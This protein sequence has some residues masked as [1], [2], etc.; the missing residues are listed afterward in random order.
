MA[1]G[2]IARKKRKAGATDINT[3]RQERYDRKDARRK[4][5]AINKGNFKTVQ[6]TST[7][8]IPQPGTQDVTLPG[9]NISRITIK[10]K[11][12]ETADP[13]YPTRGQGGS[14]MRKAMNA[15]IERGAR[16]GTTRV[17]STYGG[18]TKPLPV[19]VGEA[20]YTSV[21][22]NPQKIPGTP[23]SERTMVMKTEK[24]VPEYNKPKRRIK[25]KETGTETV[26][27]LPKQ[28][29]NRRRKKPMRKLY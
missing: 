26:K 19:Q 15:D 6:Q 9:P 21:R 18:R 10:K 2:Y 12:V 14:E 13:R 20:E 7:I 8:K 3:R 5:R 29:R 11:P 24:R 25:Y 28:K 16:Q 27:W 22:G 23:A 4:R 17:M 1:V